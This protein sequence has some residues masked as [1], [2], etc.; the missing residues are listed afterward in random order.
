MLE[1]R[2][3]FVPADPRAGAII[4]EQYLF[5][6]CGI[7]ARETDDGFVI[8]PGTPGSATVATYDD[9]R[10]AMS[11]ALLGLRW[12]GIRI[13]DPGCVAKTF[14][15]YWRALDGLRTSVGDR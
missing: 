7:D 5:E 12:P 6:C 8:R 10:M 3:I 13:A 14:P 15:G 4:D 9:H 11:F 1:H 2:A